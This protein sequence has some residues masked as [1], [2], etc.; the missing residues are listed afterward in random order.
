[1]GKRRASIGN[2]NG[3]FVDANLD[4]ALVGA[5]EG[6]TEVAFEVLLNAVGVRNLLGSIGKVEIE[7]NPVLLGKREVFVINFT[8]N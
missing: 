8:N 3:G 2:A 6:R 7:D 4:F 1:M 5:L